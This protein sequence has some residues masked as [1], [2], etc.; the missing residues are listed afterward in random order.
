MHAR[1][2]TL[3]LSKTRERIL[4]IPFFNGT[5]DEAVH[6]ATRGGLVVA[7]SGTCFDRFLRDEEYRRAI[8][9][10]DVVLP[11]S[12]FMVLLWRLL[13]RRNLNRVSGLAYLKQ[14]IAQPRLREAGDALWVLPNELSRARWQKWARASGIP[15]DD[16]AAYV[17]PMYSSDVRDDDL[18]RIVQEQRPRD[19]IVGIGAGAQEKLGYFLRENAGYRAAIHCIGGALGFITGAQVAIPDWADRLYLGWFLR[20]VSQPRVFLPRLW[21]GRVLPAL[22][23]KYGAALPPVRHS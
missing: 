4:G 11:D 17:A 9:T 10:A 19:I 5:A 21:Q 20:L 3:P 6:S 14:L 23:I 13:K 7:P 12:G 2:Q 8:V 15:P 1:E 16:V 22:L 18:L